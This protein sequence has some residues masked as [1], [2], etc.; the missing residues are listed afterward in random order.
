MRPRGNVHV[1]QQHLAIAA[2]A[3]LGLLII[4]GRQRAAAAAAGDI[5]FDQLSPEEQA[6]RKAEVQK[7]RRTF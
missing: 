3:A 7:A 2:I 4:S 6:V 5:P 1:K